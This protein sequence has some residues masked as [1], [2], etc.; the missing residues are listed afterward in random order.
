MIRRCEAFS[1][2]L[3]LW[4]HIKGFQQLPLKDQAL[5]VVVAGDGNLAGGKQRSARKA[6]SKAA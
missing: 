4:W 5:R 2:S 1:K 3:R 6:S